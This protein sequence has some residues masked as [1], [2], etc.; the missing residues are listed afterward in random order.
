MYILSV[1]VDFSQ[2][3]KLTK[4]HIKTI[5]YFRETLCHKLDNRSDHNDPSDS[6]K[7]RDAKYLTFLDII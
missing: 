5:V 3:I 4:T 6:H 7:E 1:L 2:S